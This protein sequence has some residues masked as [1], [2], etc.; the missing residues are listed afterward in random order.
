MDNQEHARYP[1]TPGKSPVETEAEG[2]GDGAELA[3]GAGLFTGIRGSSRRRLRGSPFGGSVALAGFVGGFGD[4]AGEGFSE[5][6]VLPRVER[7]GLN[8]SGGN[9]EGAEDIAGASGADASEKLDADDVVEDGLDPGSVADI[10]EN[11]PG[12]DGLAGAAG[13]FAAE[14]RVGELLVAIGGVVG[15]AVAAFGAA[16][17]ATVG[18]VVFDRDTKLTG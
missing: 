12:T 15:D 9:G 5:A 2:G 14:A 8:V 11:I 6:A 13:R 7:G 1:S 16:V 18:T 10:E 17:R 4:H 3:R